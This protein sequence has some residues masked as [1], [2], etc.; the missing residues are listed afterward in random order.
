[1][2][3]LTSVIFP[4]EGRVPVQFLGILGRFETHTSVLMPSGS[5]PGSKE[6]AP[7]FSSLGFLKTHLRVLPESER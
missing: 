3:E 6:V 2:R 4:E 5:S 7:E 1:M